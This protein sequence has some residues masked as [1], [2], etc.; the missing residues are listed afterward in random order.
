LVTT[1][2]KNIAKRPLRFKTELVLLSPQ[3]PSL[4]ISYNLSVSPDVVQPQKPLANQSGAVD[5]HRVMCKRRL[6]AA[7]A[8]SLQ[9]VCQT[10]GDDRVD[11][12]SLS[13]QEKCTVKTNEHILKYARK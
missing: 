6:N 2:R 12:T 9:S 4:L 7:N 10:H 13:L 1:R 5:A 11:C 3:S 8:A